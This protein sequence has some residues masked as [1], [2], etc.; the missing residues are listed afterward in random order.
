[1]GKLTNENLFPHETNSDL[2]AEQRTLAQPVNSLLYSRE[3]DWK[4]FFESSQSLVNMVSEMSGNSGD[5]IDAW[6]EFSYND[7][8]GSLSWVEEAIKIVDG[9]AANRDVT[10]KRLD[11]LE[12]FRDYL[13]FEY[14]RIKFEKASGT[15]G[16]CPIKGRL[17]IL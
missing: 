3:F 17:L 11:N 6:L 15:N 7:D 16:T 2:S 5:T 9:V 13:P 4:N 8:D 10:P 14:V 12:N 1:M